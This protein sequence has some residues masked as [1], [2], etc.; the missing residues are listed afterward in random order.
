MTRRKWQCY[1]KIIIDGKE[2]NDNKNN[3]ENAPVED[4][5]IFH[6]FLLKVSELHSVLCVWHRSYIFTVCTTSLAFINK[7]KTKPAFSNQFFRLYHKDKSS[8]SKV[9]FRQASNCFKRVL[10]AAKLAYANKTK[11]SITS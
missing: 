1:W 2:I 8:E 10:D 4:I 9:K 7:H 5:E 11:D 3:T 6:W